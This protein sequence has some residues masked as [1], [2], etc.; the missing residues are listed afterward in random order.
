MNKAPYNF[1]PLNDKVFFPDKETW[2]DKIS[3]DVPFK[4]GESGFITLEIKAES[5]IFVRNGNKNKEETA[6]SNINGNY[7]IPST[8]IKGMIRNV[9]EIMSFGK[10]QFVDDRKFT[11]R[12]LSNDNYTKN[13]T[14]GIKATPLTKAGFIKEVDGKWVLYP[15]DYARI[16]QFEL[17]EKIGV[18]KLS[19]VEKYDY[20]TKELGKS[21][22][23]SFS[24]S[25]PST[26]EFDKQC[27]NLK[28]AK[29][30][31]DK[32]GTLVFTGQ[33]GPRNKGGEG[34]HGR[35]KKHLE[36]V[37]FDSENNGLDIPDNMQ[38]DFKL[39][40]IDERNKDNHSGALGPN[41]EW[42][43]WKKKLIN[44]EM[45]PVFW[46][47]KE[48]IVDSF[49]LAMLY[50]LPLN[51]SVHDQFASSKKEHV[52]HIQ[53]GKFIEENFKPDLT[54]CIFGYAIKKTA[55]KGRVQFSNAFFENEEPKLIS[56][57]EEI[58]SSPKPTFYPNYLTSG[59]YSSKNKISGRKRYPVFKTIV[60]TK[61]DK[62]ISKKM[63]T[64]FIPLD[65]GSVFKTKIRFHN[66]K[67]IEIGALLSA[68]TFH[69]TDSC[70]HSLG[71]A[72]PLGYGKVK[73]NIID[74][75]LKNDLIVYLKDFEQAISDKLFTDE[76]KW[77]DSPQIT[78]LFSMASDQENS[79]DLLKY[80]T[81][82]ECKEAKK[83]PEH[84]KKYS[85]LT[86][87]N[88]P[89]SFVKNK[90]AEW[91]PVQFAMEKWKAMNDDSKLPYLYNTQQLNIEGLDDKECQKEMLYYIK[92]NMKNV[93]DKWKK[94]SVKDNKK[95]MKKKK[96]L[97]K[98]SKLA[99]ELNVD[100][101]N[102]N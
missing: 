24:I 8:S 43:Y 101:F 27:G 80:M 99:N 63:F 45:M 82:D 54:D 62:S 68:I 88:N 10:M 76:N 66:L 83:Y 35:G 75:S 92:E 16:E 34:K 17:N 13:F 23:N 18:D 59:D 26:K 57:K 46:L 85:V 79:K 91:T 40:H 71:M 98:I 81:L 55:L 29:F 58:L 77:V 37:F 100:G 42:G 56:K 102:L 25:G 21:L 19:A 50:R 72:K 2:T 28:R 97:E 14:T 15:C 67:S 53:K 69:N 7:F 86:S 96:N 65:S 52:A 74:S 30:G 4:D 22:I 32:N 9:L 94:D 87:K 70:F 6:F 41:T 44:G 48:N 89:M 47:E 11:W 36:F 33:I 31:N 60:D 64:E 20:W 61:Y 5:P 93:I 78:E 38:R 1:V 51:F 95:A 12:D 73:I 90:K 3:H 84:L 39:N 49:G